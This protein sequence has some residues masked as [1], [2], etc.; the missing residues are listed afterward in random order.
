MMC[1][2]LCFFAV[3]AFIFG[4]LLGKKAAGNRITDFLKSCEDG[5]RCVR[6]RVCVC[7]Y[8]VRNYLVLCQAAI[9]HHTANVEL[10]SGTLKF[11]WC[12]QKS[13]C[14]SLT[15]DHLLP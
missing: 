7:A 10:Y 9:C 2:F 11:H 8:I 14:Q 5:S 3:V 15:A 13:L 4:N 1:L 6:A 12:C